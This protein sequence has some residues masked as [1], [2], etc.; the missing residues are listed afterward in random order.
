MQYGRG[1]IEQRAN[2]RFR[3]RVYI[4]GKPKTLGTY[5]SRAEAESELRG[6]AALRARG[7]VDEATTPTL[8]VWGGRWLERRELAG[9]RDVENERN[10]WER[11]VHRA[12]FIDW[13]IENIRRRDVARF[14]DQLRATRAG[15]GAKRPLSWQ[16]VKHVVNLLRSALRAA[17]DDELIERNPAAGVRVTKPAGAPERWTY[18]TPEEQR[19]LLTCRDVALAERLIVAFSLGTGLRQGEQWALEL[20]DLHVDGPAPHVF[21]RWGSP[22]KPPK[23]GRTRVVPLTGIALEAA[24]AWLDQLP[25]YLTTPNGKVRYEN[26]NGLVFPT[27]RGRRRRDGK[28][29][30]GWKKHLELAGLGDA[31]KRH[32][33]RAVRWHDLRHTCAS[34]L[35]AAWWGRT[36]RLDEVRDVLGHTSVT[37]TERYAH[38]ARSVLAGAAAETRGL[39]ALP[40]G[41]GGGGG[42]GKD[43]PEERE[44]GAAAPDGRGAGE[45]QPTPAAN[46]RPG[47]PAATRGGTSRA[48]Q[49]ARGVAAGP[50]RYPNLPQSVP[51]ALAMLPAPEKVRGLRSRRPLVR[52]QCGAPRNDSGFG[53]DSAGAGTLLGRLRFCADRYVRAVASRNRFLTR[54]GLELAEASAAVLDAYMAPEQDDDAAGGGS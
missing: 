54:Y 27:L 5:G 16:T 38:L 45:G 34:S 42:G 24:K 7:E 39:P 31:S 26:V 28:P 2:G 13:P 25:G 47:S 36:W 37:V 12:R 3:A 35:V 17:V 20:R 51:E 22:G 11:H 6:H 46:D 43:S 53:D 44:E 48:E 29:P 23:N 18:L 50:P 41:G 40:P 15:Q 8:R 49:S 14:V 33:G 1:T 4:N 30:R 9:G 21:V 19:Q 32:D 52:I 10:R